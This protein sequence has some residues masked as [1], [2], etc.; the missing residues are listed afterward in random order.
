[1]T[2]S[3][4]CAPFKNPF[5][6]RE[7]VRHEDVRPRNSWPSRTLLRLLM[8]APP[9]L[10]F[11][12]LP[13]ASRS[14]RRGNS[15]H[16]PLMG[17]AFRP[18]WRDES[19]KHFFCARPLTFP[20]PFPLAG[21]SSRT[22]PSIPLQSSIICLHL[23]KWRHGPRSPSPRFSRRFLLRTNEI[24]ARRP[25]SFFS[26]LF[27]TVLLRCFRHPSIF[28]FLAFF[29]PLSASPWRSPTAWTLRRPAP[30]P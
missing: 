10:F 11:P 6:P 30:G 17:Q 29:G 2:P 20:S 24:L 12:P 8:S 13:R 1:V 14:P 7:S 26:S 25:P 5:F 27:C 3:L 16:F 19:P 9:I 15:I 4:L 23:R 28:S 22:D 18:A 21:F